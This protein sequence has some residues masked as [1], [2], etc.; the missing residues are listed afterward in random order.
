MP[1]TF[2]QL[3]R[4][5]PLLLLPWAAPLAGAGP[6]GAASEAQHR[7][8]LG[9]R[10]DRLAGE[11]GILPVTPWATPSDGSQTTRGGTGIPDAQVQALVNQVDKD[12]YFADIV[13]LANF[14]TRRTGTTGNVNA[15]NW[16]AAQFTSLGLAVTTPQ[17][18]V[19]GQPTRNVVGTL[20]GTMFPNE[21]LVVCAH[22]DSLP[23]LGSAPGAED[24]AS[25]T[26]AVLEIAR[27]VAPFG[28]QRSIRF[29]A[30][31]GEEQGVLGSTNYVANL[32]ATER[33]NF[34]GAINLDMIG[35]TGDAEHDVLLETLPFADPLQNELE[36]AAH[37][38]T[39]LAVYNSF[40][41]LGGD[42]E[43]FLNA[44]LPCVLAIENDWDTYPAYHLSSD[45]TAM[46]TRELGASITKMSL[47]AL[48]RLAN[49][50]P[51]SSSVGQDWILMGDATR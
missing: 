19:G 49:P 27:I 45:T 34:R 16:I 8:D 3:R 11:R 12:R 20:T 47:A 38:F 28:S 40:V 14:G 22:F 41:L 35:Y 2:M 25:G 10:I 23:S 36:A 43:P 29:I 32:T 18:N 37:D 50:Q 6:H 46:I 21:F 30:F 15:R 39:N 9:C 1:R 48:V 5:L 42:H 4:V 13:T 26:A 31:S 33:A 24:N 44:G 51:V 7:A 17:F